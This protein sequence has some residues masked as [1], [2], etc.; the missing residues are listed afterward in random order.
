MCENMNYCACM[1][2]LII[3]HV[4]NS[5]LFNMYENMNYSTCIKIRIIAYV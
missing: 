1:K 2:T 4:W 3:V 5:Q